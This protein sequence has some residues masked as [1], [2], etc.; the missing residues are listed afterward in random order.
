[1]WVLDF[2]RAFDS[3]DGEVIGEMEVQRLGGNYFCR[4]RIPKTWIDA[5]QFPIYIDPTIDEQVGASADDGFVRGSTFVTTDSSNI[6]GYYAAAGGVCNSWHRY[7][8]LVDISG[9]TID[10]AYISQYATNSSG[11]TALTKITADDQQSPSA[12]TNTADYNGR[13]STTAGVDWDFAPNN[14]NWIN[15]SSI[16]TVIQELADSYSPL[17]T[18]QILWKDDGTDQG[19]NHYHRPRSY[20]YD[21]GQDAVKLHIEY[22][23][24]S[25]GDLSVTLTPDTVKVQGVRIY[26]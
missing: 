6:I 13:T 16:V 18:I 21:V 24:S 12:P 10:V 23:E 25:A 7:T 22:T 19:A 2:P 15:S 8:N 26:P 9:T 14:T 5:A 3:G 17:T 11:T 20:D 1:L 4:V